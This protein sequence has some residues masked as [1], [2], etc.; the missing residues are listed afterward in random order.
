MG[1]NPTFGLILHA[2]GGLAAASFY[3]PYKGVR[4]WPWEVYWLVG[5]F[6]SWIVAPWAFALLILPRTPQILAAADGSSLFW[7]FF[8]GVAWGVGGLT[9][10]LTMRYLGIALGYAIALGLCAAFGTLVPPLF[11]GDFG[12]LLATRSGIVVLLGVGVCLVGIAVSGGAGIRKERELSDEQKRASVTEFNFPKGILVALL[13]GVMSASMAYGFAAGKPIADAA[14]AAGA[15][16]LWQNLPVLVVILLGG[17]ATNAAWCL[18]LGLRKRSLGHLLGRPIEQQQPIERQTVASD[19]RADQFADDRST[20]HSDDGG[21]ATAAPARVAPA[22]AVP[23]AAVAT[24]VLTN[25]LLCAA[26]GL[27]WYLQFFFYSMGT[28]KMGRYEFS[29]WSLHM[30]TIIIFSTVW[31][32]LLREWRGTSARTHALIVGGLAI[33]ILSMIVVGYGNYLGGPQQGE[34]ARSPERATPRLGDDTPRQAAT[35]A[36]AAKGGGRNLWYVGGPAFAVLNNAVA[37]AWTLGAAVRRSSDRQYEPD[38]HAFLLGRGVLA[39]LDRIPKPQ[40]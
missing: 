20:R 7:T 31:G 12:Q 21:T 8:F 11:A 17:F 1:A 10:G 30:A 34:A 39:N 5:G 38:T 24:P 37:K 13:C 19:G 15:P 18:M 25:Y 32:L 26:A 33:L 3:I 16:P 2:V 4:R 28:T 35:L 6:F 14:L 36:S 27:T 22:R 29:S 40:R 23:A 9:F